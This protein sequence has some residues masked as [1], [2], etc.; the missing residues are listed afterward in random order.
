M[1]TKMQCA[2][3]DCDV[4][5]AAMMTSIA[6]GEDPCYLSY[7]PK[8]MLSYVVAAITRVICHLSS[9]PVTIIFLGPCF[10]IVHS[11]TGYLSGPS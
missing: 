4:Y 5:V 11:L 8:T 2:P 7:I 3:N 6:Y 9:T 1:N 10:S